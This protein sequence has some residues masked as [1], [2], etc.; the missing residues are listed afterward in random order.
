MEKPVQELINALEEAREQNLT[1]IVEGPND[2]AAL[3]K[4]GLSNILLLNKKPLYQVIEELPASEIVILT[5][6]DREGRR[7]F[8]R[9][10]RECQHNGIKVNN[11]LRR[12]LLQ[13]PLAHIEGLATFIENRPTFSY[14][15]PTSVAT[16]AQSVSSAY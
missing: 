15:S 1:I 11:K 13:T 8:S 2:K 4:L 6:L 14:P 3:Q 9:L 12:L 5:D 10:S 16:A 7:L